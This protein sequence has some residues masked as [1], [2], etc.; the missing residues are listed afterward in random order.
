MI[1]RGWS[2]EWFYYYALHA[3][4]NAFQFE[5]RFALYTSNSVYCHSLQSWQEPFI[6][7]QWESKIQDSGKLAE[8]FLKA[9]YKQRAEYILALYT[10]QVGS[11][12]MKKGLGFLL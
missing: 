4:S 8:D 7:A 10:D 2:P 6:E 5:P 12:K 9:I 3:S 1:C 11:M